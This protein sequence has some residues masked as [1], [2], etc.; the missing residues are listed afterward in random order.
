M[1]DVIRGILAAAQG[2]RHASFEVNA[3]RKAPKPELWARK[4]GQDAERPA[5]CRFCGAQ[6]LN[7]RCLPL[8]I[9]VRV[10]EARHVQS[11]FEHRGQS[12]LVVA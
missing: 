2:H 12:V 3:T 4:V 1:A 8:E 7:G 5:R 10:V 11:S 6:T 9:S